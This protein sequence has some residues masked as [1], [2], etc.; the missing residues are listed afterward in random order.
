MHNY[1]LVFH[2][3]QKVYFAFIL[4]VKTNFV[5]EQTTHCVTEVACFHV[6]R[7]SMHNYLQVMQHSSDTYTTMALSDVCV[8]FF[9]KQKLRT[10]TLNILHTM[11]CFAFLKRM[12]ISKS[13]RNALINFNLRALN[14]GSKIYSDTCHFSLKF[15]VFL[16]QL[17]FFLNRS[18]IDLFSA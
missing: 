4:K 10:S 1:I 3:K 8:I 2:E 11:D 14:V 7:H 6:A 18:I 5:I 9:S 17:L 12:Q 16:L 13:I 15:S